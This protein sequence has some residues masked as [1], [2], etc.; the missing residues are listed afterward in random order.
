V[1]L[2]VD[3]GE[4]EKLKVEVWGDF[5]Q[6][7]MLFLYVGIH[8]LLTQLKPPRLFLGYLLIEIFDDSVKNCT[9]TQMPN[10]DVF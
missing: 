7:I 4:T 10:F 6:T 9:S 5:F 1:V 2:V 8:F 3:V